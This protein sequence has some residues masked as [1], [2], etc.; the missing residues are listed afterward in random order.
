MVITTF[1]VLGDRLSTRICAFSTECLCFKGKAESISACSGL[2]LLLAGYSIP[3][4]WALE[5]SFYS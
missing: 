1:S 3:R 2:S 4:N 5:I